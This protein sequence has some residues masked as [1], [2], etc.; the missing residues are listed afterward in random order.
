MIDIADHPDVFYYTNQ[1]EAV[2]IDEVNDF[3]V[4]AETK[5]AFTLCGEDSIIYSN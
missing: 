1:G 4:F 5:A 2:E 3:E